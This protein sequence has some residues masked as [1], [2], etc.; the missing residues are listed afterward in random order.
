MGPYICQL[1]QGSGQVNQTPKEI[2]RR[3][4]FQIEPG[5]FDWDFEIVTIGGVDACPRCS[6]FA[7]TDYQVVLLGKR[8]RLEEHLNWAEYQLTIAENNDSPGM[9]KEIGERRDEVWKLRKEL[10]T[11]LEAE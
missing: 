10:R 8:Q 7:E 6:E 5:V 3:V 11:L 9:A 4:W 1:C 2:K